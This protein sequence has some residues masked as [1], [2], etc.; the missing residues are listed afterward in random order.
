MGSINMEGCTKST[1]RCSW[2][3]EITYPNETAKA[4]VDCL[5]NQFVSHDLCDENHDRWRTGVQALLA[6]V[7][8]NPMGKVRPCDIHKLVNTLKMRKACGLGGI[9]NECL[10]HFPRSPLVYLAHLFNYCLWLSHF[11]KP[12]KEAIVITILKPNKDAEFSCPHW[13]SYLRN[14]F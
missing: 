7:D 3:F 10:R 5:E 11:P 14:L 12:W 2:S 4:I 13:L 6:P 1:N 8:N 9:P